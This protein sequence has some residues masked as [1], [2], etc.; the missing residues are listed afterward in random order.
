MPGFAD[1]IIAVLRDVDLFAVLMDRELETIADSCDVVRLEAGSLVFDVNDESRAMFIVLYGEIL[2]TRRQESEG[3][4]FL[5]QYGPGD[6]F[7]EMDLFEGAPRDATAVTLKDSELIVFPRRGLAF[8]EVLGRH[9]RISARML[10]NF[11][12]G[13]SGRLRSTHRLIK[14]KAPWIRGLE[15][16]LFTDKLTGLFNEKFL[17]EDFRLDMAGTGARTSLV[18]IKPDNFKEINDSLGHDAGDRVLMLMSIFIQSSLREGD[19]AVRYRGDEFAVIMPGTDAAEASI[20][21]LDIGKTLQEMDIDGITGGSAGRIS[22]SMGIAVYP[23]HTRERRAL[24]DLAHE[25]MMK[26]RRRGGGRIV[27]GRDESDKQEQ[28]S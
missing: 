17:L 15:K 20:A 22:V 6:Y 2:V 24:I 10:Y 19:I 16:E 3:E 25:K 12:A 7:G 5:A 8:D 13:L 4:M 21:A 18:M 28:D 14:E 27:A 9:P 26:A 11:I 23:D 1:E